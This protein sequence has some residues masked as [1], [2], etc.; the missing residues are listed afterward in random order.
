MK[1]KDIFQIRKILDSWGDV[2][3]DIS[4]TIMKNIELCDILIN[5]LNNLKVIDKED[6]ILQKNKLL[7][8]YS[9]ELN[10]NKYIIDDDKKEE[11]NNLM[12]ELDY[13]LIKT[14]EILNN[15]CNIKFYK[16]SKEKIPDGLSANQIKEIS[17]MIE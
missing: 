12:D 15:E 10:G 11:F 4:Y 5:T 9:S 6:Y 7:K 16:I 13:N 3:G 8:K 14:S 17:F 2:R 1:N